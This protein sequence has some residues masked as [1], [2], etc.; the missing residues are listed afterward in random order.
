MFSRNITQAYPGNKPTKFGGGGGNP[1]CGSGT[2]KSVK[3]IFS[4]VAT[5][6]KI[7]LRQIAFFG[8]TVPW[9]VQKTCFGVVEFFSLYGWFLDLES[10]PMISYGYRRAKS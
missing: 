3:K 9:N 1:S 8:V 10:F 4:S 7:L 5:R 2:P 6:K